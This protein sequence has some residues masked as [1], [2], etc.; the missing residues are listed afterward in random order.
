MQTN[1]L[2]AYLERIQFAGQRTASLDTLRELHQ[3]HTEAIPFENLSPLLGE[4]VVLDIPSL[5][6]KLVRNGRGG[7]CYE[8]NLLFKE[9]LSQF[10]FEVKGLAARVRW[11]VPDPVTTGR[12]HMLLLVTI[13]GS[14]W[15]ADV[16]F[17]GMTLTE[18]LRLE[19]GLEQTTS[20][21]SF[22]LMQ[23][24]D[25]YQLEVRLDGTWKPIYLFDLSRQSLTDYQI[26]NWYVS[27]HPNSIFVHSLIAARPESGRRH[28]LHNNRYSIHHLNSEAEQHVLSAAELRRTLEQVFHI[29]LP[30]T[31][32][33]DRRLVTLC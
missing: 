32:E 15:I 3:R 13:E 16:G 22:R 27:R 4:E 28:S 10:G 18:P 30:D 2:D 26:A 23:S 24:G 14:P 29:R 25:D 31:A 33:L 19:T 8:H 21:E 5:I 11:N 9:V 1:D 17:G 20:H 12:T 6:Q 7:Y